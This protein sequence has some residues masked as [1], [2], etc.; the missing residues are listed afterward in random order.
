VCTSGV[1]PHEEGAHDDDVCRLILA[2][3]RDQIG[4][5]T[6]GMVM[7]MVMVMVVVVMVM[8]IMMVKIT[9]MV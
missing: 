6:V 3:R 9:V 5:C 8:V 7:V 2:F 4:L 1:A